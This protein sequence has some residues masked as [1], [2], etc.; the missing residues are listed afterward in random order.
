MHEH[1][2]PVN[3]QVATLIES[4]RPAGAGIPTGVRYDGVPPASTESGRRDQALMP[5][6]P[7]AV[8]RPE[9]SLFQ[10]RMISSAP[11]RP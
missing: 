1:E 9:N 2:S 4:A 7:T 5:A 10:V 6:A 3:E 11:L 8:C